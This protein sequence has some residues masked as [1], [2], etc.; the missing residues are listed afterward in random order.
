MYLHLR[1][2]PPRGLHGQVLQRRSVQLE[3]V[4]RVDRVYPQAVREHGDH[5]PLAQARVD[6]VAQAVLALCDVR[7][8]VFEYLVAQAVHAREDDV[9]YHLMGL[10]DDAPDGFLLDR[11]DA[12]LG[13]VLALRHERALTRAGPQKVPPLM[14]SMLGSE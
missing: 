6:G 1:L 4:P 5:R 7:V 8:D 2:Y 3:Q 10:L 13:G 14:L 9:G 11:D 12:V